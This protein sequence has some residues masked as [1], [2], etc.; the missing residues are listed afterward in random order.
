M[1]G[2]LDTTDKVREMLG[3]IYKEHECFNDLQWTPILMMKFN[4]LENQK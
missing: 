1:Q 3:L 4:S 2:I